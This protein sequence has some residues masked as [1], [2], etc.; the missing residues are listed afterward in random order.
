[1]NEL[2]KQFEINNYV[3]YHKSHI[4]V[5][6]DPNV[7]LISE[8]FDKIIEDTFNELELI[9]LF[10]GVRA[11]KIEKIQGIEDFFKQILKNKYTSLK[12]VKLLG[13]DGVNFTLDISL[14][15]Q[16]VDFL[17]NLE[18]FECKNLS[19]TSQQFASAS[20]LGLKEFNCTCID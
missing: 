16:F 11:I 17:K 9:D 18:V 6:I 19:L 12:Y 3:N 1:M 8:N 10:T 2:L 15:N 7:L 14:F 20:E 5:Y 4:D 13:Y